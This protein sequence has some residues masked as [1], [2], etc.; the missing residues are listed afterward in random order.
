MSQNNGPEAQFRVHSSFI[1]EGS[2][3]RAVTQKYL[4]GALEQF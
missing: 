1:Q 4:C 2:Y 3:V